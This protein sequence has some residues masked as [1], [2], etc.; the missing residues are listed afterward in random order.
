MSIDKA[1][2]RIEN[3]ELELAAAKENLEGYEE[4]PKKGR[5]RGDPVVM[6]D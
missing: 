2:K 5:T 1:K 6:L 4:P 3:A